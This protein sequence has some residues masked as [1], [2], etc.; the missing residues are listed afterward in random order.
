MDHINNPIPTNNPPIIPVGIQMGDN[1]IHQLHLAHIPMP[2]NFE[3][4]ND[5]VKLMYMIMA[6]TLINL[7]AFIGYQVEFPNRSLFPNM[8][9]F[10][11]TNIVHPNHCYF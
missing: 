6:V 3:R 8:H 9:K 7:S 4:I 5:V 1:A 11:H 10:Y 2:K